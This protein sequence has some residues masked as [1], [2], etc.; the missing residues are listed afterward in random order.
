MAA[1]MPR[2]CAEAIAV[3]L[4]A[5]VV[6]TPVVAAISG[7]VSLVAVLANVLVAPA[8]GPTTVLGFAGGLLAVVVPALGQLIGL[9]AGGFAWWIVTVARQGADLGGAA[10]AWPVGMFAIGGLCALCIGQAVLLTTMLRHRW[11]CLLVTAVVLVYVLHPPGRP[12]WPPDGWRMVMCDVG[13][14]DG[15]VLNAGG[16]V[17]VVV[18]AGPD[19]ELIDR[20]LD[21]LDLDAVALVVL[22]HFHADHV[23]GLEG[24]LDGRTI[25][26]IEVSPIADPA[27]RAREVGEIADR[28]G[29]PVTVGVA[30]ASRVVGEVS[31]LTLGPPTIDGTP[32]TSYADDGSGPNN[33]SL[34]IRATIGELDVL[35]A[36]DSEVEEQTAI[37]RTGADLDADVL[38]VAHHGSANQDADFVLA[39]HAAV[40]LVSV[41]ADNNYGH[42]AGHLL[43]LLRELGA[44]VY[45][46]DEHGDIAVTERT[47]GELAVVPW[48]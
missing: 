10:I 22:T 18:D 47:V 45:R 44:R 12:G 29:V 1:W 23:D 43:G 13:Q 34:V 4:A 26:E 38:K 28:A 41:G 15:I 14:G 16:G 46:T 27:S 37:L 6:C 42:P 24:V 8:V 21:R 9:A 39:S 19:P 7:Q 5:Q 20:C 32:P 2:W 17:G 48:T 35:L 40:A 3:P 36:G 30:G 33:A 25:G 11:P 31:L